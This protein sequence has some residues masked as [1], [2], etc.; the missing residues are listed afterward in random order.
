MIRI[1]KTKIPA[2]PLLLIGMMTLGHAASAA[3]P[4]NASSHHATFTHHH[5]MTETR[6][7][8]ALVRPAVSGVVP[9]AI[10]GGHPLQMLNPFAPAKYGSAEDNVVLDPAVPGQGDGIKLF[11]I[12]F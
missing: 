2:V 11:S 4:P 10:R 1:M 9:R 6:P 12:P 7:P 8:P 3:V 5:H